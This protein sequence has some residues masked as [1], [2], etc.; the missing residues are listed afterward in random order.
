MRV[1]T[2]VGD[3]PILSRIWLTGQKA[4]LVGLTPARRRVLFLRTNQLKTGTFSKK[5]C[6]PALSPNVNARKCME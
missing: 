2:R 5:A 6:K 4:P 3:R 1:R